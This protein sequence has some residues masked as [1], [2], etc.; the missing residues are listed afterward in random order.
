MKKI[1][2]FL[3]LAIVNN[4]Y[5]QLNPCTDGTQ[6]SCQCSYAPILCSISELNGLTFSMSTYLHPQDGPQGGMCTIGD[7]A[8]SENPEWFA[9]VANCTDLSIRVT[10]T[11]CSDGDNGPGICA[12]VQAAVYGDCSNF[13]GSV[14]GCNTVGQ[15]N[16]TSGFRTINMTNLIVGKTYYFLVDGC[17]GS[18]CQIL[19]E[20]LSPPCPPG[21]GN[22]PNP[23][24]GPDILDTNETGS[25]TFNTILGGIYF[26][27]YINGIPTNIVETIENVPIASFTRTFSFS[28]PGVYQLCVEASNNCVNESSPPAPLCKTITVV[29]NDMD[30]DGIIDEIDNCINIFNPDQ[31]DSDDDSIGDLCDNCPFVANPDQLDCNNNGIGD[32]CDELD[33][34]CDGIYDTEDNCPGIANPFQTDQ[35]NNNIGDACEEFPK[36]GINTQDPKTELHLSNG[37]LFIDNP[38]KGI[39]LKDY[40]GN[41]FIIKVINDSLG[42]QS[43]PCPN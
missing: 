9:F 39:I 19:I 7:G 15:C 3:C 11:G 21:L 4:G 24:S 28:T 43:I 41:C 38:E 18:A 30:G 20:V 32:I 29:Q 34:D 2:F 8:T 35:N 23:M 16:S 36:L 25:Y 33:T 26:S 6:P 40:Q 42:L 10:Y 22:W 13:Y 27:W 31:L 14:V 12:G 5:A 37:S 17:C 1:I